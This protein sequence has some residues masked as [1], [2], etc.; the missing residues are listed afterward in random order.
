MQQDVSNRF[1]VA[2]GCVGDQVVSVLRDTGC[3]RVIVKSEFVQDEQLTEDIANITLLDASTVKAPLAKIAVDCPYYKGEV[4]AL[5]ITNSLHDLITGNADGA[6]MPIHCEYQ[7]AA[8]TKAQGK[9]NKA[10]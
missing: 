3:N 8:V 1:T 6:K 7:A 4:T 5:C 10:I 2:T 9:I